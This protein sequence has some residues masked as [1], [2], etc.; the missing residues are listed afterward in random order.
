MGGSAV[1]HAALFALVAAG[2]G[3]APGPSA[4]PS[5]EVAL[6]DVEVAPQVEEAVPAHAAETGAGGG[7]QVYPTHTHPYPVPFDHDAHPHDPNLVHLP[8]G[9]PAPAEPAAAASEDAPPTFH[10]AAVSVSASASA[11]AGS[12]PSAGAGAGAGTGPSADPNAIYGASGVSVSAVAVSTVLPVYPPAARQAGLEGTVV[13]EI[14]VDTSGV[15]FDA[16][17]ARP[18]GHGFDESAVAAVRRF[19]FSPALLHGS[20]VRVRMFWPVEFRLR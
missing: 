1:V 11:G 18:A 7:G 15:V 8:L 19:R 9:A 20:P 3:A 17:V 16:R 2:H 5:P 4:A 13:V 10:L 12:G 6:V 14:L